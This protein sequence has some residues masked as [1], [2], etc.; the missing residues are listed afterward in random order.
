MKY[1]DWSAITEKRVRVAISLIVNSADGQTSHYQ[2]PSQNGVCYFI[3]ILFL[4]SIFIL[5]Y[6]YFIVF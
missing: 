5:F 3:I 2:Q 1:A 4:F 6:F